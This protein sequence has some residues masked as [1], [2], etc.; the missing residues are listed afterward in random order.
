MSGGASPQTDQ[1]G[2]TRPVR[3][4]DAF[5]SY[6]HSADAR[7]APAVRKCLQG[8]GRPW[9]RLRAMRVFQDQTNL[10]ANPDLW[11]TI[12]S[13]LQRSRYFVLMASPQ[14]AASP[15]VGHEIGYWLEHRERET[16]LIALTGG[17]IAWD[18]AAGDFDWLR[19]TALPERLRGWFAAEPLWVD[20][21]WARRDT[22]LSLRYSRFRDAVAT[23]AATIRGVPKENL[24]GED[25]RQHR[26]M[27][28]TVTSV[29]VTVVVALTLLSVVAVQQASDAHRQADNAMAV[30]RQAV[31]QELASQSQDPSLD[32]AQPGLSQLLSVAAWRLNP[33]VQARAAMVAALG[34]PGIAALPPGNSPLPPPT[35]LGYHLTP[36]GR[37][38]Q[39][40]APD[41]APVGSPLPGSSAEISPDGRVIATAGDG[42]MSLWDA[43]DHQELGPPLTGVQSNGL[44]SPD[45]HLVAAIGDNQ[46]IRVW[47]V[48]SH[49]LAADLPE[50]VSGAGKPVFAFSPDDRTV[51]M[52]TTD[53]TVQ[54]W[55][56]V[57]QQPIGTAL[58]GHT[59]AISSIAFSQDGQTLAA[60]GDDQ[61]IRLWS[62]RTHQQIGAP[63]TGHAGPVASLA[64][65]PDNRTLV[66][67]DSEQNVRL[68]DVSGR[69][70]LSDPRIADVPGVQ[71]I[72]FDPHGRTLAI[73]GLGENEVRI[74]NLGAD[75]PGAPLGVPGAS[76]P[77]LL[78][79]LTFSPDGRTLT[80]AA[81]EGND[82]NTDALRRWD[83]RTGQPVGAP[84]IVPDASPWS[85]E[86]QPSLSSASGSLATPSGGHGE[87]VT[88]WNA[89]SHQQLGAPWPG[90]TTDILPGVETVVLS[91]DGRTLATV[92]GDGTV[93]LWSVATHAPLGAPLTTGQVNPVGPLAF[94]PD[95]SILAAGDQSDN[96]V[97]LW[98]TRTHQPFGAPLTGS[99][100]P[101]T[102]LAFSPDG[103]IL[104]AGNQ[105]DSSVHLWDVAGQTPV[106]D[107]LPTT[108]PVTALAFSPQ[109][110]TLA[111]ATGDDV[112]LWQ[113]PSTAHLDAMLCARV[114]RALTP[115]E[116]KRYVSPVLP[117]QQICP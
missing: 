9:H 28:R 37:S 112:R 87:T 5:L 83:A 18:Q 41:G 70:G 65:E 75:R 24:E 113:V 91:P 53:N 55:D 36:D 1:D 22:P 51:A 96:S 54:L 100:G 52:A 95:G 4:Y 62:V 82:D 50:S 23:L 80:T 76:G 89:A 38:V 2:R 69:I 34:R 10:A 46:T 15:W 20:L 90:N 61:T 60:G 86:A 116:W 66:S 21:T 32:E 56:L 72:A 85:G 79:T 78:V 48:A 57:S 35:T 98:D 47:N 11:K 3:E 29:T 17:E 16:F 30:L 6:S 107:P 110:E 115:D 58:T 106:G 33:S 114:G 42:S 14:A 44:F 108:K 39:L 109:G 74:W 77:A 13:A 93:Q 49:R 25:I 40:Q 97:R 99:L 19:T 88:L 103:S 27:I 31:S 12:E 43:A 26:R 73:S 111:A 45:S 67:T 59:Q 104:A 92:D 81:A 68:W 105:G 117:Y 8:L 84:W 94:S 71:S 101:V 64:F 7:L 102:A 63:L